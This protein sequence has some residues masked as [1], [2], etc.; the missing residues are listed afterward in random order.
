MI[1]GGRIAAALLG[2]VLSGCATAT[3]TP[4]AAPTAAADPAEHRLPRFIGFVGPIEQHDPPFLGVAHTNFYCLRSFLDRQTGDVAHQLYVADSYFGAERHWD[5]AED[6]AG[7][8]LPFVL[9]SSAEI[10]CGDGCV[11]ADEFAANLPE[12]LLRSSPEGLAV[13]FTAHSGDGLTIR[14]SGDEIRHQLAAVDA[15]RSRLLSPTAAH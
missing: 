13:T 12:A 4:R 14:L 3:T 11:Y 15:I 5:G 6:G 10:T 8:K 1:R 7:Q 2:A 9:I